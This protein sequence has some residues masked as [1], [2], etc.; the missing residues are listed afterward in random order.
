MFRYTVDLNIIKRIKEVVEQTLI[1]NHKEKL[2]IR[3]KA[4][5]C[6]NDAI[7]LDI[8]LPEN[9]MDTLVSMMK[10]LGAAKLGITKIIL[11]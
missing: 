2:N 8:T 6:D 9:E 3:I 11:E 10:A 1:D 7:V 5:P 4:S